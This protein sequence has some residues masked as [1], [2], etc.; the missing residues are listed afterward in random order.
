[1][2]KPIATRDEEALKLHELAEQRGLVLLEA[3]HIRYAQASF[4]L[5]DVRAKSNDDE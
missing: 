3:M 1:V 4:Y 5:I 2:E